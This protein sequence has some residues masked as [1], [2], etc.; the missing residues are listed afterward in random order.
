MDVVLRDFGEICEPSG[1]VCLVGFLPE[2]G[3]LVV[4]G[5]TMDRFLPVRAFWRKT[6]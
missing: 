4:V 2:R 6:P 3:F 5:V 1:D